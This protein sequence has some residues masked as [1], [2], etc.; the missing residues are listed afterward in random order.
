MS[1]KRNLQVMLIL[2][3]KL[4]GHLANQIQRHSHVQGFGTNTEKRLQIQIQ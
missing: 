2:P 4:F 1:D 3:M